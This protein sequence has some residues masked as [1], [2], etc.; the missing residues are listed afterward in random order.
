MTNGF[1]AKEDKLGEG[2]EDP[3]FRLS[4]QSMPR[5]CG[6]GEGWVGGDSGPGAIG[7]AIKI[8]ERCPGDPSFQNPGLSPSILCAHNWEMLQGPSK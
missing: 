3:S 1:L 4:S 6:D 8:P 2:W 7:M 5:V